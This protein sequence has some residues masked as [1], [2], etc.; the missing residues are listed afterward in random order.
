MAGAEQ[1]ARLLFGID[2]VERLIDQRNAFLQVSHVVIDVVDLEQRPAGPMLLVALE[3]DRD[4]PA[5]QAEGLVES[6]LIPPQG[7]LE[8]QED[9]PLESILRPSL[10][11]S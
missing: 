3:K 7:G 11:C 8:I 1:E 9:R 6:T 10:R 5:K 2:Q 4:R